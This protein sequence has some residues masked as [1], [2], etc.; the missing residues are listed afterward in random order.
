MTSEL[1]RRRELYRNF[2][3]RRVRRFIIQIKHLPKSPF[4]TAKSKWA[5]DSS[6][7]FGSGLYSKVFPPPYR[8]IGRDPDIQEDGSHIN[9]N[10]TIDANVFKRWRADPTYRPAN[11]VEWAQRKKVERAQLQTSVQADDPRLEVPDQ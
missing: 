10:E 3:D 1:W 7:P 2:N 11:L 6:K 5:T 4:E 9:I 8:T